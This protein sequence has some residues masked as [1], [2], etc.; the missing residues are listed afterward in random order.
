[1]VCEAFPELVKISMAAHQPGFCGVMVAGACCIHLL[2]T[3]LFSLMF[4]LQDIAVA[5]LDAAVRPQ[6]ALA[7]Q[8]LA[9]ADQQQRQQQEVS[10]LRALQLSIPADRTWMAAANGVTLFGVSCRAASRQLR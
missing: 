7:L 4:W 1:V 3:Q 9:S 8:L 10:S 2:K 6:V 5:A